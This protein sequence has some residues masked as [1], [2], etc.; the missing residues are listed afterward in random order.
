MTRRPDRASWSSQR[1]LR[2]L[3]DIPRQDGNPHVIVGNREGRHLTNLQKPWVRIRSKLG[4]PDV[5]VHDLRHTVASMLAR[6]APLVV[7]RDALGHQVIE[8]TLGYSHAAND[9]VRVAVDE[10]PSRSR[11]PD[12]KE[13]HRRKLPEKRGHNL[14]TR[15]RPSSS[16]STGEKGG[17]LTPAMRPTSTGLRKR[18]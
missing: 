6:S 11:G 8:T 13:L 3:E 17:C 15:G 9:D 16:K 12:E 10:L 4:F 7:V 1:A 14:P 2:L 18:R 5:R